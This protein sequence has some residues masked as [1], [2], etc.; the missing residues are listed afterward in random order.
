MMKIDIAIRRLAF[1]KYLYEVG[2]EQSRKAEPFCQISI[3]TLQDAIELF[4]GLASEFIGV[5][6]LPK[7]I[8]FMQYWGLINA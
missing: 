5:E 4:L 6:K 8:K 1:I 3:L 7:D 2:V